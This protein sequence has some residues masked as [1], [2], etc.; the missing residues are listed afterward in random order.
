MTDADTSIAGYD[1]G[2]SQLPGSPVSMGQLA[3]L[4]QAV[5]LT[6]EDQ[7]WLYRAGDLVANR[8]SEI[9]A[10][11]RDAIAAL[12]HLA[13]Y[14]GSNDG[15]IDPEYKSRVGQRFEQWILDT[16]RLPYDRAW[17]D[18]QH[19]IALR[20]THL[21]KNLTDQV[22]A[23]PHIPLRYLIAFSAVINDRIKPFLRIG[24]TPEEADAMHSA[25]CK[26]VLL[27]VALWSRP[28]ASEADW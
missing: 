18:Y 22:D 20:H 21:K 16:C 13:A 10:A 25:W 23:L 8:T 15:V 9:V 27:Q 26:S 28:Y 3:L 19:E 24:A 2:N 12:P 17:L 14:Y 7:H 6:D 4:K 11:W 5:M 1:F